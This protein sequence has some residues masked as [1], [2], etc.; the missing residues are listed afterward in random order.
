M[1][2]FRH[3]KTQAERRADQALAA[4]GKES[5]IKV[6]GRRRSG[7]SGTALPTERDDKFP[8]AYRDRSRGKKRPRQHPA[9][10]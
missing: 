8:A 3:P 5:G 1:S 9:G 6:K 7:R 2:P 10:S 4:S